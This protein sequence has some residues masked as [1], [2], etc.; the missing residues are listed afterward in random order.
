[1]RPYKKE[2]KSKNEIS[3]KKIVSLIILGSIGGLVLS[4][5]FDAVL[6]QQRISEA[7]K[8]GHAQRMDQ[9]ANEAIERASKNKNHVEDKKEKRQFQ[10][11]RKE[12]RPSPSREEI[13]QYVA[14]IFDSESSIAWAIYTIDCESGFNIYAKNGSGAT[15]LFQ[16]LPK[17]YKSNAGTDLYNWKEQVRVAKSMYDAGQQG[18]WDDYNFCE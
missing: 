1:M 13:K 6:N 3:W 4:I 2:A 8:S 18:Q 17:T 10:E 5:S 14:K 15:G 12:D 7:I 9:E 16:F 11:P